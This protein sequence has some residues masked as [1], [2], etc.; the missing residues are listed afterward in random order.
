[1]LLRASATVA[2]FHAGEALQ[3]KTAFSFTRTGATRG[4]RKQS[5]LADPIAESSLSVTGHG[6]AENTK[7]DTGKRVSQAGKSRTRYACSCRWHWG[8]GNDKRSLDQ[9]RQSIRVPGI[10]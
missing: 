10:A 9:P 7:S 4:S 6:L 3:I 2:W 8:A 5:K 1:M